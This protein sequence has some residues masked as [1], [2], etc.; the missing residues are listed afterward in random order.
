MSHPLESLESA[1]EQLPAPHGP[2]GPVTSSIED[3][4]DGRTTLAVLG[5]T[6]RQVGMVMLHADQRHA[7]ALERVRRREV[8]RVKVVSDDLGRD[9]EE[10]LEMRDP[11]G[12]GSQ[13]LE[14]LEIADVVAEPGPPSAARQKVLLSS[15]PHASSGGVASGSSRL[16]G[17]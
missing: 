16:A 5:E 8:V 1:E 17:T 4:A 2:V 3:H 14:V 15:A 10:P 9:G 11:L 6:R 13:R 12:E 7:V